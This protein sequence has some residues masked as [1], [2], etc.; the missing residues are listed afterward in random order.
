M[1]DSTRLED[2]VMMEDRHDQEPPGWLPRTPA[3]ARF[4]PG[5]VRPIAAREDHPSLTIGLEVLGLTN[6]EM[7]MSQTELYEDLVL[8]S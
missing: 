1:A 5:P 8:G 4:V 6:K 2:L 3:D 7:T